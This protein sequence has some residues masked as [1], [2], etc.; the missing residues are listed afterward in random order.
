M[1]PAEEARQTSGRP[2]DE[3]RA[4]HEPTTCQDGQVDGGDEEE[5]GGHEG[6][7]GGGAQGLSDVGLVGRA[8]EKLCFEFFYLLTVTFGPF[9]GDGLPVLVVAS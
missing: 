8:G 1:Q 2:K 5:E 7:E 6:K 3:A 4:A 9:R